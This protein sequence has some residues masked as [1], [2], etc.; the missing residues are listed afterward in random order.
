ML[1]AVRQ[2]QPY[3]KSCLVGRG[4]GGAIPILTDLASAFADYFVG[5]AL[6]Y[7]SEGYF[8]EKRTSDFSSL[9]HP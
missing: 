2:G 5:T 9:H 4:D 3:G 7:S 1:G 8:E 6:K